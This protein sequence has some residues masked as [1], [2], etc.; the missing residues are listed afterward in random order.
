MANLAGY[1]I[2]SANWREQLRK[3]TRRTRFVL[4]FFVMIYVSLGLIID[5]Y[6]LS[7]FYPDAPLSLIYKALFFFAVTPYATIILSCIAALSILITYSF[8]DRM[9]LLGTDYHRVTAT[10]AE[11]VLEKQLWNVVEEMKVAA[12]MNYIPRVYII[13]AN[14]M[15]AFA[16]GYS[17]R[18]AMVAITRGLLEKL[19]R[20]ELTAVMAHELSHIRHGDIKLT[21]TIGVLSNIMLIV[22]DIL[23]HVVIFNPRRSEDNRLAMIIIILRY[24]L[25]IITVLLTLF[26]SRTREYMADAGC[27]ELMRDNQP[28]ARALL[29]IHNDHQEHTQSYRREY[30][31]TPHEEVRR[32]AYLYDP[33]GAGVE[34]IKSL[35]SALSTHPGLKERLAAIGISLKGS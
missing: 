32:A 4:V 34:P 7:T 13:E 3:N 23:F 11:T 1:D 26:L 31:L 8:Y 10:N 24:T 16:S 12:G 21:L 17:E 20:A 35:D 27:V 6:V 22:I 33:V 15:N 9:M 19:D 25:P 2:G 18:S 5:G 29:K 28:L 30:G 14:Y